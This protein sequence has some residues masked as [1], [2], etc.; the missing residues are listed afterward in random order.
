MAVVRIDHV[1]ICFKED[2]QLATKQVMRLNTRSDIN[3]NGRVNVEK[4]PHFLVW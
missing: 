1:Y 3:D 4:N 2:E